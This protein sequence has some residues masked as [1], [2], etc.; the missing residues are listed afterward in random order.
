MIVYRL[1]KSK[2]G[3]DLSGVGSILVEGRWHLAGALPVLYTASNRSLAI[4]EVLAHLPSPTVKPPKLTLLE[5]QIPGTTV[6][7]IRDTTLPKGWESRNYQRAVQV[8]G[9]KWLKANTSLAISVPSAISGDRNVLINPLH[10][11][12]R[13]VK[14]VRSEPDFLVDE[15][16]I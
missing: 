6:V 7:V 3:K 11:D 14:V 8:W 15:R 10:P 2:H 12:F 13:K 1:A 16:L 4:L 9:T 5:I